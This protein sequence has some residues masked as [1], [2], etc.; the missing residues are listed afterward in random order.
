MGP[1]AEGHDPQIEVHRDTLIGSLPAE[2]SVSVVE[3]AKLA[4]PDRRLVVLDDD[5][6]GTQAV[7]DVPVLTSWEP[8]D[9]R[10]ALERPTTGFFVLTN[11]RSLSEVVA[12][13]RIRTITERCIDAA[14]DAGVRLTFASRSDSTLRGHFPLETDTITEV[15]ASRGL[16]TDGVIVLPAYIDAGRITVNSDHWVRIPNSSYIPVGASQFALDESFGFAQSNLAQ[17]VEEKTLGRVPADHVERFTIVDIRVGGPSMLADRLLRIQLGG[18]VVVDAVTDNDL[19]V[20]IQALR[21]TEAGG[22]QFVCRVGPSFVRAYLG[23]SAAPP[24]IPS[25]LLAGRTSLSN[26]LIVVGSHVPVTSRQL[27]ILHE[28]LCLKVIELDVS[29]V[30]T[31]GGDQYVDT[32]AA[33][34]V[35]SLRTETVVLQTTRQLQRGRD[36]EDSLQIAR[37]VSAATSRI[38][39][40]AAEQTDLRYILAK[41]GIT[42][43]DVATKLGISRAWVQG[44]ML[45]GIVSAWLPTGGI[46]SGVPFIVFPGNVGDPDALAEV[47]QRLEQ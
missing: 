11:T 30:L 4:D 44:S 9:I 8:D 36:G 15:L 33:Q 31:F 13:D 14:A 26:G 2:R 6:T 41:G 23:Q 22:R 29:D 37:G 12:A 18:V 20:L 1:R 3:M 5:P 28:R 34:V 19:R 32:V 42:S 38:A 43:S 45:P 7:A 10:W 21:V 25:E 39:R 27:A 16:V 46:A 35:Q 40:I 47:V 24:I 17:W